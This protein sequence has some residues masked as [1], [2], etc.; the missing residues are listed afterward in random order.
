M[1]PSTHWQYFKATGTRSTRRR[2]KANARARA[3]SDQKGLFART[4]GSSKRDISDCTIAS[5][6]RD[7]P[8]N[9]L[10]DNNHDQDSNIETTNGTKQSSRSETHPAGGQTTLPPTKQ[11]HQPKPRHAL[12][13]SAGRLQP[14][15][16]E[17]SPA[18]HS[19][20]AS[21]RTHR[22]PHE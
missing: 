15:S 7:H 13:E 2:S 3:P 21:K 17:Q 19:S 1:P 18:H 14:P 6:S 12:A 11:D 4:S 20:I 8:A 22:H 16:A 9:T 10:Q 5:S